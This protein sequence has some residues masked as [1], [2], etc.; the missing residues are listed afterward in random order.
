M[1]PEKIAD[2]PYKPGT[3]EHKV[4]IQSNVITKQLDRSTVAWSDAKKIAD[5]RLLK[6]S[7]QHN[8]IATV[9]SIAL[10]QLIASMPV[11]QQ[12]APE[13]LAAIALVGEV[14]K[15]WEATWQGITHPFMREI[16]YLP[17]IKNAPE[18]ATK[19]QMLG[20]LYNASAVDIKEMQRCHGYMQFAM[21][22]PISWNMCVGSPNTATQPDQSFAVAAIEY[23]QYVLPD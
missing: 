17:Q 16:I 14:N 1:E 4:W 10:E 13:R 6:L 19:R 12:Y 15:I 21:Y 3:E 5:D 9:R 11:S 23:K 20:V 8:T 22:R 2:C 7:V 18:W